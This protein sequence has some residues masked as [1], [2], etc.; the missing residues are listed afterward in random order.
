MNMPILSRIYIELGVN[1]EYAF[2][3]LHAL[4]FFEKALVL[5]EHLAWKQD[6]A[7]VLCNIAYLLSLL[8]NSSINK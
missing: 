3:F 8:S 1:Y 6:I 4:H 5:Y 7:K 2:E